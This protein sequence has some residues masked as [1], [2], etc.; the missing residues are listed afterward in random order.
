MNEFDTPQTEFE[1]PRREGLRVGLPWE[2]HE[3]GMTP[4]TLL[5]SARMVLFSPA[6]AFG[7]MRIE[8]SMAPPLL[9][10]VA[11]GTI[12]MFF[13]LLWQTWSRALMI[14]LG[15][16][17]FEDV[18]AANSIGLMSFVLAPVVTLLM[19]VIATGVHHLFLLMFGGAPRPIDVTLRVVCF[20]WGASY[21]WLILPLCGG[22]I[23]TIWG[24][25]ATV[26]GLREA[27]GVP[28]GR[29]AAAVLVPYLFAL[30]CMMIATV[31]LYSAALAGL[32]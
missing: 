32:Q 19:A 3:P 13:G 21:I 7:M 24:A 25:V 31:F 1:P 29:A 16:P 18:L 5:E 17:A 15:G 9:F 27:Q 14:S 22:F 6:D 2:R 26:V 28:G 23:A 30:C 12:G 20:A 10:L 11:L 8:G 4:G